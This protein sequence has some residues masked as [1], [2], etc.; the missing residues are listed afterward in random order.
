MMKLW[1]GYAN[2]R[3]TQKY[4]RKDDPCEHLARWMKAWGEE[5]QPE[6]VHILY[7]SLDMIPTN[8]YLETELRHRNVEWDVLKESFL[9]TFSFEDGFECIYEVLQEIKATIFIIPKEPV[10]RVQPG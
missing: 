9:L 5:P 4:T 10:A 8:W 1:F 3:I 7:H 6:L 2:T